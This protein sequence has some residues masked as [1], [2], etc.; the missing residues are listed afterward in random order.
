MRDLW[1]WVDG[2]KVGNTEDFGILFDDEADCIKQAKEYSQSD[3][4]KLVRLQIESS[5]LFVKE[6]SKQ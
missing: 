5:E 3:S 1:C 6:W 4:F 2:D